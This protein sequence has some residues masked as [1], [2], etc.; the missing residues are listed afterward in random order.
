MVCTLSKAMRSFS[1]TDQ[2]FIEW[3]YS[4]NS[5]HVCFASERKRRCKLGS[6]WPD[7]K[8]RGQPPKQ[9]ALGRG[10]LAGRWFRAE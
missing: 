1:P 4:S 3:L 2:C 5:K 8:S 10:H 6:R 7:Q 9:T